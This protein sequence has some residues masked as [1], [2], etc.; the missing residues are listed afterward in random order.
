MSPHSHGLGKRPRSMAAVA[1]PPGPHS[2]LALTRE[3][4]QPLLFFSLFLSFS[5]RLANTENM[6]SP[7]LWLLPSDPVN[8]LS[9]Y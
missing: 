6:L 4:C 1:L 8:L 9:L 3:G 2:D 5:L 7:T